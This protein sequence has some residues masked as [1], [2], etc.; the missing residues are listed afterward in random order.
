MLDKNLTRV[1]NCYEKYIF[2]KKPAS[3]MITISCI[4]TL[5]LHMDVKNN[6]INLY[7]S[8]P[9]PQKSTKK[10]THTHTKIE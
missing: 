2:K 5:R 7:P 6:K 3:I 1:K 4:W 8:T 9:P 10:H